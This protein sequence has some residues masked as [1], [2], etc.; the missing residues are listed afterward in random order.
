ML[1]VVGHGAPVVS[2]DRDLVDLEIVDTLKDIDL[3]T[4]RPVGAVLPPSGPGGTTD[5]HVDGVHEDETSGEHQLAVQS[6]GS[7]VT[8]EV[9]GRV[10]LHDS[11]TLVVDRHETGVPL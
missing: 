4:D 9:L 7:S 1:L 5:G 6:D 8:A 10:D 2:V 11:I 3:S